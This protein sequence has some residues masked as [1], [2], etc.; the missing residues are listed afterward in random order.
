MCSVD[1]GLLQFN[2]RTTVIVQPVERAEHAQPGLT[3][4]GAVN[5]GLE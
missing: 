1:D 2:R 3:Q 4:V 5:V